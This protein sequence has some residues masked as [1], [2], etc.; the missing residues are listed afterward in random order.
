[1]PE[2]GCMDRAVGPS[3]DRRLVRSLSVLT[4]AQRPSTQVAWCLGV[5]RDRLLRDGSRRA[6]ARRG[7]KRPRCRSSISSSIE[8]LRMV[9]PC[10]RGVGV[11]STPMREQ[12][13]CPRE[14]ERAP[15]RTL[16]R[17][18][19]PPS[20]SERGDLQ[21]AR[22][23][24]ASRRMRRRA[25][26]SVPWHARCIVPLDDPGTSV[27]ELA[28]DCAGPTIRDRRWRCDRAARRAL[29]SRAATSSRP[30]LA[31]LRRRV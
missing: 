6:G 18:A 26:P 8:N 17:D 28:P 1:M 25:R 9:L 20:A 27:P 4:R 7:R 12:G 23:S 21:R 2:S 14:R 11:A 29:C 5:Q 15:R 16:H 13:T 30:A 19:T 10:L 31:A 3:G 24:A 22:Q